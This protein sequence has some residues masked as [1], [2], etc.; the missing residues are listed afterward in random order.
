MEG[1]LPPVSHQIGV[2]AYRT[3][4]DTEVTHSDDTLVVSADLPRA[5]SQ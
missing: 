2:H 3:D 1:Y 5:T 4:I